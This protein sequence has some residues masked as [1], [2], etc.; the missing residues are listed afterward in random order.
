M[1]KRKTLMLGNAWLIG[2]GAKLR[3]L[4]N[5]ASSTAIETGRPTEYYMAYAL[6]ARICRPIDSS[7]IPCR[8]DLDTG[9][10]QLDFQEKKQ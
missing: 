5:V 10:H 1:S 7:H 9:N 3:H 4:R 8:D 2:P 6:K